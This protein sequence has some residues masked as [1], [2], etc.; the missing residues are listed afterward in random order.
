MEVLSYPWI[1]AALDKLPRNAR[2]LPG[3][4]LLTGRP[5]LGKRETVL[6]LAASLLCE[7]PRQALQACGSCASCLLLKA[8]NHPD[9][10][11]LEI[12]QEEEG[13]NPA[14][15]DEERPKGS[16]KPAKTISVDRAR[17]LL[18]FVTITAHRG[19]TKVVCIVPAE[20]L[21][22]AAANAVLKMLEEPPGDTRFLLASHRPD[23]VLPTIRSRCFHLAIVLPGI[24][25]ALEWLQ[26]EGVDRPELALAQG[27]YAPLAARDLAGDEAYWERRKALL[28]SLASRAFDPVRSAELAEDIDGAVAATMLSR[29]A[30]DIFSLKSGGKV[31]YH[32]DYA[33]DLQKRAAS[34]A[35]EELRAWYEAVVR[36]GRVAQHPLNKRL[37]MES[38]F[39]AYPGS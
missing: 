15:G 20:A 24:T 12:G 34:V 39:S 21:H 11:V 22:P 14:E 5:G 35:P 23:R 6:F 32:L 31:R 1:S 38:L 16:K 9:L 2:D 29:W 7:T 30:Y 17:A 37:A 4:L 33:A 26:K 13:E 19:G 25:P 36:F 28:D 27:G 18:D 10:R 3:A 8:G